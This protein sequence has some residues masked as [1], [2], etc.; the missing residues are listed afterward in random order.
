MYAYETTPSDLDVVQWI[1][2]GAPEVVV[3]VT[4]DDSSS[5]EGIRTEC[6]E[7]FLHVCGLHDGRVACF[8]Q[9]HVGTYSSTEGRIV[10]DTVRAVPDGEGRVTVLASRPE[11]PLADHAGT[12]PVTDLAC[13][14]MPATSQPHPGR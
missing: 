13:L 10:E 6:R 4:H 7:T 1:P 8:G 3:T 9:L 5:D 14:D 2:G 12:Y 11:G